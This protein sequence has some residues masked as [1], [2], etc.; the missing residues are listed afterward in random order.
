MRT[1]IVKELR[2]L[3]LPATLVAAASLLPLLLFAGNEQS[4]GLYEATIRLF[5]LGFY[6]GIPL[7]AATSFGAEFQQ[8][9]MVLLLVQPVSR[10]RIWGEKW[11][12]LV[13][14]VA[15]IVC[16]QALTLRFLPPDAN[17]AIGAAALYLLA[18]LCSAPL[19]TLV[20]GSTTGGLVFSIAA[21]AIVELSATY[22][23]QWLSGDALSRNRHSS[24]RAIPAWPSHTFRHASDWVQS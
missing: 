23:V 24:L 5:M 1:R 13:I 9:T 7:L 8:Q 4:R 17:R 14:S 21:F 20:A 22:G 11:A 18:V 3:L 15:L 6:L 16:L 2:A 19:W 12:A 10:L